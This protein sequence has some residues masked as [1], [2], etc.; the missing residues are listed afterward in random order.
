MNI[1]PLKDK[2]HRKIN[3]DEHGP[4]GRNEGKT[5]S[6]KRNGISRGNKG[7]TLPQRYGAIEIT[8]KS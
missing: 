1:L 2:S 3:I 8:E 6:T 4:V 7:Q 5:F